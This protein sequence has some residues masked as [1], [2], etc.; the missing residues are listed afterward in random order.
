MWWRK[1]IIYETIKHAISKVSNETVQFQKQFS[2]QVE[3]FII[4]LRC[5][6]IKDTW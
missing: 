4:E 3:A 5:I 6:R 2:S 1:K